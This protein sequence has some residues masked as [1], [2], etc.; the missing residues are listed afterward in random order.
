M[1]PESELAVNPALA[2]AA[3]GKSGK[4]K[5]KRV[6]PADI[7]IDPNFFSGR[8]KEE[9]KRAQEAKFT[10]NE[11]LSVLLLATHDAKLQHFV[12][13]KSSCCIYGIDGNPPRASAKKQKINHVHKI[14][15]KLFYVLSLFANF[16]KRTN[17]RI[18]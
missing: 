7:K 3:G 2:K 1:N 18:N 12:R 11:D 6:R 9:M 17:K 15:N 4:F 10:Q 14:K 5:G 8:H 16:K 13:A